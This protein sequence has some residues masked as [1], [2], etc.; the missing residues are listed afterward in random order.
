MSIKLVAATVQLVTLTVTATPIPMCAHI[1][2]ISES[3]MMRRQHAPS[4]ESM[5][6]DMDYADVGLDPDNKEAAKMYR[7]IVIEAYR[8]PR[9]KSNEDRLEVAK[10]F[11]AKWGA[12][13]WETQLST[14]KKGY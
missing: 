7:Q 14:A 9:A 10:A 12:Q 3:T 1:Y 11:G 2:A 6:S 5:K 4:S 13:C 8:A